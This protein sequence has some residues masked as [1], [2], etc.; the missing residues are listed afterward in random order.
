M[1]R[2]IAAGLVTV[3]MAGSGGVQARPAA[4]EIAAASGAELVVGQRDDERAALAAMRRSLLDLASLQEMHHGG[5]RGYGNDLAELGF[6]APAGVTVTVLEA[7]EAGWS[8]SSAHQAVSGKSCVIYFG[9]AQ[10]PTTAGGKRPTRAAA[11]AC[12]G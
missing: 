10:I 1:R 9:K 6:R 12:D 5:S 2:G 11:L 7:S 3:L 4:A 8:A